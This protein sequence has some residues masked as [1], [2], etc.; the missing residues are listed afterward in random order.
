MQE[1]GRCGENECGK[2]I[3][4]VNNH[5]SLTLE[6]I[7]KAAYDLEGDVGYLARK[8]QIEPN[9]ELGIGCSDLCYNGKPYSFE[10]SIVA[11]SL[12]PD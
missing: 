5:E 8:Y 9:Q 12:V 7:V 2:S 11:S 6:F 4:V 10:R 1:G 3:L